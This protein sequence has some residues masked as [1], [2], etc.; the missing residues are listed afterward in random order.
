MARRDKKGI[1][2]LAIFQ[3]PP[4]TS[5]VPNLKVLGL[6]HD[7]TKRLQEIV[8]LNSMYY[9]TWIEPAPNY[10]T[11]TQQL[12]KRGYSTPKS[13]AP[14]VQLHQGYRG[15]TSGLQVRKTMIRRKS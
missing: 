11:L 4:V 6:G 3:G 12:S 8:D 14:A 5:R 9:E 2:L 10:T 13:H 7:E 1:R 15:N